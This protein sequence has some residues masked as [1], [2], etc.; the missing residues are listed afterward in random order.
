M[1]ERGWEAVRDVVLQ[2]WTLMGLLEMLLAE[3]VE[4]AVILADNIY[5]TPLGQSHGPYNLAII[6][7]NG[8]HHYMPN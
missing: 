7:S 3:L 2:V 4:E 6:P 5:L 1:S 8:I